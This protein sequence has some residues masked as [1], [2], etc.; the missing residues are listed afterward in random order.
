MLSMSQQVTNSFQTKR[1]IALV[2]VLLT[3]EVGAANAAITKGIQQLRTNVNAAEN[4]MFLCFPGNTNPTS[5]SFRDVTATLEATPS[6]HVFNKRTVVVVLS[7]SWEGARAGPRTARYRW[8]LD[9]KAINTST[10]PDHYSLRHSGASLTLVGPGRDDEGTYRCQAMS[11]NG[12]VIA[13][14]TA[15]LVHK[16]GRTRAGI[17]NV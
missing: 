1:Y 15:A 5:L 11:T 9:G 3:R 16:D 6:V 10:R 14:S 2:I 17:S 4:Y 13:N 12:H 7:C 8:L